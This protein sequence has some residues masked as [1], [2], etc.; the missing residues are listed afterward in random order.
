MYLGDPRT[1]ISQTSQK[2]IW[3]AFPPETPRMSRGGRH[4]G[5]TLS[6]RWYPCYDFVPSSRPLHLHFVT[7]PSCAVSTRWA[8][9]G[10]LYKM[11]AVR[12]RGRGRGGVG[13]EHV[14]CLC[15]AN[16]DGGNIDAQRLGCRFGHPPWPD[17]F[18]SCT[19]SSDMEA[20]DGSK[21]PSS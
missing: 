10:S 18:R 19:I 2:D 15:P 12:L 21:E 14:C 13:S 16:A 6:V 1:D 17:A 5:A 20:P 11:G 3:S 8:A 4:H 7:L 9:V